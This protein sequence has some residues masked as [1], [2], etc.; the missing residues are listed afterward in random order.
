MNR[1][2]IGNNI[3]RILDERKLS[4]LWLAKQ[5]GAKNTIFTPWLNGKALPSLMSL[6]RISR[7][8]GVT[9]DSLMEGIDDDRTEGQGSHQDAG[10]PER[11]GGPGGA[12]GG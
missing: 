11:D 1:Y 8:L 2:A 3:R 10:V 5:I 7:V 12:G 9:M 6:Y 4:Q